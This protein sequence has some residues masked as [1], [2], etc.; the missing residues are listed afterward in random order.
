MLIEVL[1]RL[2]LFYLNVKNTKAKSTL[3]KKFIILK[4]F[5][6]FKFKTQN[7]RLNNNYKVTRD[8]LRKGNDY[9]E[10]LVKIFYCTVN[11]FKCFDISLLSLLFTKFVV[12]P[13][14]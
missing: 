6:A 1:K 9:S 5:T 10:E 12:I 3:V 4:K 14:L 2:F 13:S 7:L 11:L 8:V